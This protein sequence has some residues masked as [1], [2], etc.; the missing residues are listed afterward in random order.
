MPEEGS[1]SEDKS[2]LGTF[3]KSQEAQA[4]KIFDRY[5][6]DE[7]GTLNSFEEATQM[8]TNLCFSFKYDIVSEE[9]RV[10]LLPLED[11]ENSPMNF[12]EFL[13]WFQRTFS[14]MKATG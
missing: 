2:Q 14:D 8:T 6:L 13:V 10:R 11:V 9:I 4:K 7:S 1:N 3:T 12:Q 5:D